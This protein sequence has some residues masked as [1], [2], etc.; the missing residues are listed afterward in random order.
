MPLQVKSNPALPREVI[1]YVREQRRYL[2][3]HKH[4]QSPIVSCRLY[5]QSVGIGYFRDP[6]PQVHGAQHPVSPLPADSIGIGVSTA[7]GGNEA[8]LHDDPLQE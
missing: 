7:D 4:R 5:H 6:E 1:E 8:G 2:T 3:R